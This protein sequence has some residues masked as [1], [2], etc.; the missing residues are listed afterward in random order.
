MKGR[1]RFCAL[2]LALLVLLLAGCAGRNRWLTVS[3]VW[4]NADS[5]D[6]KRIRVRGEADLNF[7]P[8]HPMQTGGCSLDRDFVKSTHIVAKLALVDGDS[9]DP[10]QRILISDSSLQC[11]GNVCGIV[12]RPFAPSDTWGRV[13]PDAEVFE[14]VGVLRVDTREGQR[15]LILEEIDLQASRR[16]AEDEWGPIPTGSFSYVFP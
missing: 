3:D 12:C 1:N 10:D 14:F 13:N 5:L 9:P 8:R 2:V 7:I 16:M 15:V 6:G 4:Q 11:E